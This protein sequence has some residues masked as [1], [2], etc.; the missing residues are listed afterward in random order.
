MKLKLTRL[1]KREARMIRKEREL[2]ARIKEVE[3]E[4]WA[5]EEARIKHESAALRYEVKRRWA[6]YDRRKDPK[7]KDEIGRIIQEAHEE[8]VELASP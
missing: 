6:E 8:G 5:A 3:M 7:I 4:R 2:E 1:G